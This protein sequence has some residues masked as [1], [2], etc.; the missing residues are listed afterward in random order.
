MSIG[1]Y[2]LYRSV[3]L[4]FGGGAALFLV[5]PAGL[6][7]CAGFFIMFGYLLFEALSFNDFCNA[8]KTNDGSLLRSMLIVRIA[9]PSAFSSAGC[10]ALLSAPR[11]IPINRAV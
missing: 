2:A 4:V 3:P 10:W 6:S 5:L 11:W 7:L 1:L 8:T 9:A